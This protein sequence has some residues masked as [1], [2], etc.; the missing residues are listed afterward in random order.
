MFMNVDGGANVHICTNRNIFY[1]F[2]ESECNVQHVGVSN[3][4]DTGYGLI[5]SRSKEGK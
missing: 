2:K 3:I 5:F 1:I 4:L